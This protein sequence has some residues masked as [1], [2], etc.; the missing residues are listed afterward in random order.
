MN[1]QKEKRYQGAIVLQ[2]LLLGSPHTEIEI[3]NGRNE[4]LKMETCDICNLY[5][6]GT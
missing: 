6:M 4:K 3:I 1:I 5:P 2:Q